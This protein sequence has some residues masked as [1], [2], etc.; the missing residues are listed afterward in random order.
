MVQSIHLLTNKF[1]IGVFL[2]SKKKTVKYKKNRKMNK[3]R[4]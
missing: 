4:Y 1:N 2:L 3:I